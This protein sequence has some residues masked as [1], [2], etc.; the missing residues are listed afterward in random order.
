MHQAT[1][2]SRPGV[3]PLS[4]TTVSLPMLKG[5]HA[6]PNHH[7]Q[8]RVFLLSEWLTFLPGWKMSFQGILRDQKG[9]QAWI[10][11]DGSKTK[12]KAQPEKENTSCF[13]VSWWISTGDPSFESLWYKF[14]KGLHTWYLLEYGEKRQSW[15]HV[16]FSIQHLHLF[17]QKRG[18]IIERKSRVRY[19]RTKKVIK[20][21]AGIRTG[22]VGRWKYRLTK[23]DSNSIHRRPWLVAQSEEHSPGKRNVPGSN[24]GRSLGHY[25]CVRYYLTL[26]FLSHL[27]LINESPLHL[28]VEEWVSILRNRNNV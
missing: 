6:G 15:N 13:F 2:H 16:R 19:Y 28:A 24:P 25:F 7:L 20:R 23:S 22:D 9:S 14:T 18:Y 10:R 1:I 26:L 4:R 5:K 3:R 12:N 11:M 17:D 27:H 21:P 8:T